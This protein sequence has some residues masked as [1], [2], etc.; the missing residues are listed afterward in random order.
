MGYWGR[1]SVLIHNLINIFGRLSRENERGECEICHCRRKN[2][3]KNTQ[4][5]SGNFAQAKL[6]ETEDLLKHLAD[7]VDDTG[8]DEKSRQRRADGARLACDD[9]PRAL[10]IAQ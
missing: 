4:K 6:P 1:Q 2:V 10:R 5:I 9:T 3:R 7:E 8:G